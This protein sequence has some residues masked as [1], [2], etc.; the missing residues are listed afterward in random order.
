MRRLI[1]LL[2]LTLTATG[3]LVSGGPIAGARASH[4]RPSGGATV[5]V[6]PSYVLVHPG[7]QFS[8]QIRI[9][10]TGTV[11]GAD[12]WLHFDP[13][14]LTAVTVIDG[15]AL[16]VRLG[17]A[18]DN[19]NGVVKYGAGTFG[20]GVQPPFTLCTIVFRAK[21]PLGTSNLTLDAGHTDVQGPSGSI[22]G[23]LVHGR[24]NI[25]PAPTATATP[26]STATPLPTAT[27]T[28]TG[29]PTP[30]PTPTATPT[31]LPVHICALVYND[32]DANG[33]RDRDEP[34]VEGATLRLYTRDRNL[35]AEDT[36]RDT[37][38]LCF[39]DQEAGVYIL[40]EENLPGYR[41]TTADVWGLYLDAGAD[42]LVEFGDVPE[43]GSVRGVLFEDANDNGRQ[44]AGERVVPGARLRLEGIGSGRGR[45]QGR[46]ETQTDARGRYTFDQVAF[47][48]YTLSVVETPPGYLLPAPTTV[49]VTKRRPAVQV[50]LPAPPAAFHTYVPLVAK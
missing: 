13:T 19:T 22:L 24:V 9:E 50:D 11:V 32:L 21:G 34:L 14:L 18:I 10:G 27:P 4:A 47:G 1:F 48:A 20:A 16:D 29:T 45:L 26:T 28:P 3:L 49:N 30:T 5:A 46:Y 35:I 36:S 37:G 15:G 17:Q 8:I 33:F 23:G 6:R 41:S 31:P 43:Y 39:P 42:A 38:P 2:L 7:Q 12:M 25:T 44:D 40:S